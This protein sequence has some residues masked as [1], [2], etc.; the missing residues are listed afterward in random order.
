MENLRRKHQREIETI[1]TEEESEQKNTISL[2]QRQNLTLETKC[3]VF[4]EQIKSIE[5]RIKELQVIIDNKNK[6]LLE[7]D[8]KRNALDKMH[9]AKVEDLYIKIANLT[10]EKEKLRHKAIRA[11]LKVNG[12]SDFSVEGLLKKL[13]SVK[14]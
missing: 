5:P 6:Q 8:E 10:K 1:K 7:K 14:I 3:D 2:L 4:Q 12:D 13:S 9:H 11:Q